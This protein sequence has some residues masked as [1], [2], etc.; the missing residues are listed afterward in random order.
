MPFLAVALYTFTQS[1][2]Y[3]LKRTKRILCHT[4]TGRTRA[5]IMRKF[6]CEPNDVC[7]RTHENSK[8]TRLYAN[9]LLIIINKITVLDAIL[10]VHAFR[11]MNITILML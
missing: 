9:Y 2:E 10:T 5:L 8:H 7:G 3:K 6:C 4:V 11:N 1:I